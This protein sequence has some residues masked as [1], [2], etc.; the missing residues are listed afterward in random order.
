MFLKDFDLKKYNKILYLLSDLCVSDKNIIVSDALL[1]VD[2]TYCGIND[3]FVLYYDTKLLDTKR[4]INMKLKFEKEKNIR[5]IITTGDLLRVVFT[6]PKNYLLDYNLRIKYGI[7]YVNKTAL[8]KMMLF[9]G[10][11]NY[12]VLQLIYKET[13]ATIM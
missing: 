13:R 4:L 1:D 9:W 5:N 8:Q 11:Y 6:I 7:K 2:I 10:E 12:L 3:V